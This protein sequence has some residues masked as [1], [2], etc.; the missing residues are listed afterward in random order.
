MK[1]IVFLT[2]ISIVFGQ[3]GNPVTD[4]LTR[5]LEMSQQ[6]KR[7]QAIQQEQRIQEELLRMKREEHDAAMRRMAQEAPQPATQVISTVDSPSL[8]EQAARSIFTN[9]LQNGIGWK[10][11]EQMSKLNYVLGVR[12]ALLMTGKGRIEHD[13][14]FAK[15]LN[16][17]EIVTAIDRFYEEP[18]NLLMIVINALQFISLK[19]RGI[20]PTDL[21]QFLSVCRKF[22]SEAPEFNPSPAKP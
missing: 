21:D 12:D 8:P 7:T 6:I 4:G 19:A 5:A 1:L 10:G 13:R 18:E 3:T 9:G 22:A 2:G 14:Y 15:G 16:N 17:G 20:L 11:S